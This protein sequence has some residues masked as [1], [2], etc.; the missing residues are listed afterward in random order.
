MI[1]REE[2]CLRHG[3]QEFWLVDSQRASVKMVRAGGYSNLYD[4]AGTIESRVLGG[5]VAVRDIFGA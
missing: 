3:G 2:I 4:S 5:S 1:E